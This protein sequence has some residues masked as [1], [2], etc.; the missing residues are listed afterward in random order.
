MTSLP[1]FACFDVV[2]DPH[3]DEDIRRYLAHLDANIAA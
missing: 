2:K 1:T 3:I